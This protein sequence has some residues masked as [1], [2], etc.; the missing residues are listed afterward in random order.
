MA[1]F[2]PVLFVRVPQPLVGEPKR[3]EWMS[4]PM[5]SRNAEVTTIAPDPFRERRYF[6]GTQDEGVWVYD[7]GT[8]KYVAAPATAAAATFTQQR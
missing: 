6:M 5:P 3:S 1:F 4:L 7:G 8:E 2:P